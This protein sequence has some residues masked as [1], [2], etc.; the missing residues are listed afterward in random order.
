MRVISVDRGE[1][2]V[3]L[4]RHELVIINNALNEVRDALD[5]WEFS[6]RMGAEVEEAERLLADV[7]SLFRA[8]PE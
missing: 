7:D 8:L 1:A 3:V 6:T 5:V 4:T 2:H